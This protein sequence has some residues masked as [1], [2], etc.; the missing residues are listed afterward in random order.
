MG[1]H[2]HPITEII[3]RALV[4]GRR[5]GT[6]MDLS[7][8]GAKAIVAEVRRSIAH[9]EIVPCWEAALT[10]M[11]FLSSRDDAKE[12]VGELKWLRDQLKPEAERAFVIQSSSHAANAEIVQAKA[13]VLRGEKCERH[14]EMM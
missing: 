4:P 2:E 6:S 13:A 3:W 1:R 12:A 7:R 10:L 5:G 9:G 8:E 14:A 11:G